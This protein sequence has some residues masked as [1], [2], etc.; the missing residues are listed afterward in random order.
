[1][2]SVDAANELPYF[3]ELGILPFDTRMGHGGCG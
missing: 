3:A 1:M 2:F